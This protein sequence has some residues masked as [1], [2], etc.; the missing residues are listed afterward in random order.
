MNFHIVAPI[1]KRNKAPSLEEIKF[2][3]KQTTNPVTR[4]IYRQIIIS[5]TEEQMLKRD[6]Q[7]K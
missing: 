4:A 6:L 5:R 3:W 2:C 7:L 1:C